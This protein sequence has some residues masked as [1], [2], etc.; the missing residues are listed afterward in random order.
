MFLLLGF[1]HPIVSFCNGQCNQLRSSLMT[2]WKL[3]RRQCCIWVLARLPSTCCL[4]LP[5]FGTHAHIAETV[6]LHALPIWTYRLF[7]SPCSGW[8][9]RRQLHCWL[10]A[11]L[12]LCLAPP[13]C[14]STASSSCRRNLVIGTDPVE[15]RLLPCLRALNIA[16]GAEACARAN[17]RRATFREI[18]L[19]AKHGNRVEVELQAP[20]C[21]QPIKFAKELQDGEVAQVYPIRNVHRARIERLGRPNGEVIDLAAELV[22]CV[23]SPRGEHEAPCSIERFEGRARECSAV[24]LGGGAALLLQGEQCLHHS[25]AVL[26]FCLCSSSAHIKCSYSCGGQQALH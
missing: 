20:L 25:V 7:S 17:P 23:D 24:G 1:L 2:Y 14:K 3:A 12:E 16:V 15:E 11:V 10:Q 19:E 22:L 8:G 26:C 18:E 9:G 4:Q 21:L 5:L 13:E 6:S